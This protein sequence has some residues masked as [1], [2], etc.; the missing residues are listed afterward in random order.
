VL[1]PVLLVLGLGLAAYGPRAVEESVDS[2]FGRYYT[3]GSVAWHGGDIY[4]IYGD[5]EFKYLP[6]VAQGFSLLAGP[7]ELLAEAVYDE[8]APAARWTEKGADLLPGTP[9][10]AGLRIGAAAW[11]ALLCFSYLACI[12]MAVDMVRPVRL[13]ETLVMGGVAILL[14]GR[15]FAMNIRL[16]QLNMFVMLWAVLG[17][18]LVV[19]RRALLGGAAVAV[20]TALKIIPGGILLWLVWRRNWRGAGAFCVVGLALLWLAPMLTWGPSDGL[21]KTASWFQARHDWVTDLPSRDAPGQSLPSM[22]NRFLR[23]TSAVTQRHERTLYIN[24]VDSPELAKA[25]AV[26]LFALACLLAVTAWRGRLWDPPVRAGLEVGLLFLLLLLVSPESRRA[27]FITG[28]VP[29]AA[30]AGHAL[31]RRAWG[32][33]GPALVLAFVTW[34]LSSSGV[35]GYS[36][37]YY[38]LNAYGVVLL[39]A[40]VLFFTIRA[41]LRGLPVKPPPE[42]VSPA[43]PPAGGPSP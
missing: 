36:T 14:T 8:P 17:C 11:Y 38:Y 25:A 27:H 37:P 39:G 32:W 18:W 21:A 22:A 16:G 4:Y 28:L 13:R 20:A 42:S 26:L 24:V 43:S 35:W 6:V 15:F 40:L 2:D 34:N 41:A 3:A 10:D 23:R 5:L 31:R 33:V 30:L 9:T 29:A 1:G 19:R 7:S 12:A